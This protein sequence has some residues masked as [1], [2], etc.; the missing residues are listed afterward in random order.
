MNFVFCIT[1]F[2]ES[3]FKVDDTQFVV[4]YT[5]TILPYKSVTSTVTIFWEQCRFFD[6][7]SLLI[8]VSFR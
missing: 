6:S 4:D 5:F 1:P 8:I 2:N 3:L 7:M